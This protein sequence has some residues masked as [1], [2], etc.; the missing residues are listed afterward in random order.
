[1][2]ILVWVFAAY[3]SVIQDKEEVCFVLATRAS[4]QREEEIKAHA[5]A[6]PKLEEKKIKERLIEDGFNLCISSITPK[7][8]QLLSGT[9]IRPY[10]T[11]S[12]LVSVSLDKYK[13]PKNLEISKKFYD[14]RINIGKRI[15]LKSMRT[16]T[17]L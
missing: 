14:N 12:H 10:D 1:M 3:A 6:N 9:K 5:E 4:T 2:W 7:E 11:Y 15:A 16:P 8:T 17:D 13:K